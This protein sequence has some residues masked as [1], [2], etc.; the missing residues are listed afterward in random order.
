VCD[1]A[2]GQFTPT[3][4]WDGGGGVIVTWVDDRNLGYDIYAARLDG[5]GS[6]VWGVAGVALCTSDSIML[7]PTAMPDGAGGAFVLFGQ[8][9]TSAYSDVFVQH[10]TSLGAISSGWPTNG[11]STVP[12][13]CQ[14]FGA[15]PTNDGFLLMGWIDLEG[16]LRAL[17]LTGAGAIPS[18][19]SAAGLPIGRPNNQGGVQVC[20]DGTG[21][22]Y[23]AWVQSDSVMLTR[24]SPGGGFAPGWSAAGTVVCSITP[25][26]DRIS[27]ALL[28][29]ND[30]M[31]FW[32]DFRS[33]TDLDIYAMRYTAAGVPGTGWPG[34]GVQVNVG[35]G[36]QGQPAAISDG[37]GGA[38]VVFRTGIDTLAAQRVNADGSIPAGWPEEGRTL[39]WR[40]NPSPSFPVEDGSNGAL[41]AFSASAG[42]EDDVFGQRVGSN[43]AI[44]IGWPANGQDVC[45]VSS[46]Q[47]DPQ[48]VSDGSSG[49]IAVWTDQRD[50]NYQRLYAARV[51][52]DG[53]VA[54][55]AALVS[56]AAEPGL[57]RLQWFSP[58]GAAFE[59]ALE[60]AEGGGEFAPIDRVRADALGHVRY[61]DRNVA[62]GRTYSYRLAVAEEGGIHYLGAVTLRV[63]DGLRFSLAG[64]LPNPAVGPPR[65]AYT[66]AS[67]ERAR[68]DVLDPAGRRVMARELDS[69]P[70]EHVVT[71]DGASLGPGV[72][73]LR[74][75]Q[76]SRSV[77][78]RAA[79][80]R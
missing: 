25:V 60:R 7:Q 12:D 76:G 22:G 56:A 11:R 71:L 78:A 72:Y 73:L 29:G 64:F 18:G 13:G 41:V 49:M 62:A 61:E 40:S 6:P 50:V 21:G 30:V 58:D 9:G 34:N 32:V 2:S 3:V 74:L 69:A 43:G 33:G 35:P 31:V 5:N 42:F 57:V 26:S 46:W 54:A 45:V 53:T 15:I 52:S 10:V 23:L 14:G 79:L 59:A 77:V 17:R 75:T 36:Q 8:Y 66:L 70:G 39:T 1:V 51:Q 48:I 38:V 65:L 37:A 27:V 67:S 80:V 63:P 55:S 16:Q 24:V 47:V 4:T 19:W 28:A 44:P 68:I 20:P